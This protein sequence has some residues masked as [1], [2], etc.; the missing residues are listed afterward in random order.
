MNTL[1]SLFFS[2]VRTFNNWKLSDRSTTFNAVAILLLMLIN[3]ILMIPISAKIAI[4]TFTSADIPDYQIDS[5]IQ[6]SYKMRYLQVVGSEILYIVMFVFYSY[7]LRLIVKL[8]GG[9][10]S[11]KKV[12]QLIVSSYLVIV[13]GDLINTFLLYI[14]GVDSI[15]NIYDTSLVSANLFTSINQVGTVM[16]TLLSY[17]SPFQL[18]FVVLVGLGLSILC[19]MKKRKAFIISFLFWIITILIPVLSVYYSQGNVGN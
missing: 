10:I 7:I 2:P 17:V 6:V 14:R 1:L 19:D 13:I 3:L 5:M 9:F 15:K 18:Y 4:I 16:Y 11:F 8:G 12:F